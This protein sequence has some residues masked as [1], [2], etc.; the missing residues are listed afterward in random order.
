MST[1]KQIYL[2]DDDAAVCHALSVFLEASGYLVRT[3]SC[4]EDFLSAAAREMQG[5]MLLDQRMTGMTGLE[6]QAE[7]GSRGVELP[8]IFITGHGDVRMSVRALKAGA[9]NFLEK[10]FSNKELLSVLQEAFAGAAEGQELHDEISKL[11]KLH[12]CLTQ[13]EREVMQYVVAGMS[14][15]KLADKLGVSDRTIEVHRARGMKKMG[16]ESLPDLVRKYSLLK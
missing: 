4:A 7:L 15:R 13:R 8:I 12:A 11:R 9:V 2:V 3:F 14:N 6:L 16:A 1:L 10:P 5:V